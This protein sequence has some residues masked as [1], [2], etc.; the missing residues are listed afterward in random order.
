MQE[1][2]ANAQ[3]RTSL[4]NDGEVPPKIAKTEKQM[5]S[6]W[7]LPNQPSSPVGEQPEMGDPTGEKSKEH[8]IAETK[9]F[10]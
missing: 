9:I 3:M 10:T 2:N 6:Q 1:A 8:E 5:T 7:D 4:L